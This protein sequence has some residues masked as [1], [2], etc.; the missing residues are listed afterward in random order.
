MRTL[1]LIIAIAIVSGCS[2]RTES[3]EQA[4]RQYFDVMRSG[5]YAAAAAMFD[6]A[7]LQSFRT[8]M[9]F[10][11]NLPPAV[12]DE[13]FANFFGPEATQESVKNLTNNEYFASV[14]SF[15]MMQSG[16]MQ[17][18][19]VADFEYL[20]HV[21]EGDNIAHA[22]TRVSVD[23]PDLSFEN[24]SIASYIRRGDHW[25][26]QMSA[27]IRGVAERLKSAVGQ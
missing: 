12:R 8:S 26:M 9:S 22:V 7:E 15:A 6:P 14:Y 1:Q 25:K 2:A 11:A 18:M 27:D 3:V 24:L 5:D 23:T 19:N 17:V 10:L 21:M 16:M 20:G 4:T 13:L